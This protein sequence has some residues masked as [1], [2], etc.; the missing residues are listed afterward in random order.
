M[1]HLVYKLYKSP[2]LGEGVGLEGASSFDKYFTYSYKMA[3]EKVQHKE[4]SFLKSFLSGGVGGI[5]LVCTGHPL[6]TIK[7]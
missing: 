2:C 1:H 4:P 7:V 6:D 3:G 5:A